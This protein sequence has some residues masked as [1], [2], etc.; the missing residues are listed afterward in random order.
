MAGVPEGYLG[1]TLKSM[2]ERGLSKITHWI[3]CS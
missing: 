1:N 2:N 3:L